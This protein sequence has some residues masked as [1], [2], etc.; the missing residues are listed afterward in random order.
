[1]N[2]GQA[3]V[4]VD[5]I[6]CKSCTMADIINAARAEVAVHSQTDVVDSSDGRRVPLFCIH[7]F[8]A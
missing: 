8:P 6:Q 7:I 1:M 2:P 3:P 5:F 4:G